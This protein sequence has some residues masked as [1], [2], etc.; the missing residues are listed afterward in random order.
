MSSDPEVLGFASTVGLVLSPA[1]GGPGLVS[2]VGL[3]VLSGAATG[4]VVGFA[5]GSLFN[6]PLPS[7]PTVRLCLQAPSSL[8][9]STSSTPIRPCNGRTTLR[10]FLATDLSSHSSRVGS[11][12]LLTASIRVRTTLL[13]TVQRQ[14]RLA[15]SSWLARLRSLQVCLDQTA[16][17]CWRGQDRSMKAC[18]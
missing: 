17:Q 8:T 6:L 12:Q 16:S 13:A 2:S 1:S 9:T 18:Q 7:A 4:W 15:F 14:A 5:S 10:S 3:V 11:T